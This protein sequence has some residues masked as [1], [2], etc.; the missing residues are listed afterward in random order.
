METIILLTEMTYSRAILLQGMLANESIPSFLSNINQIQSDVSAGVKVMI[1]KSDLPVALRI[2]QKM[3][4]SSE[5]H[6][7][8]DLR[9]LKAIRRILVPVDFSV[10]SEKAAH[11][12]LG[13]AR[14]LKGTIYLLHA[15]YSPAISATA[16]N[17]TF[18][19]PEGMNTYLKELAANARK[20]INL[21]AEVLRKRIHDE[22]MEGVEV[23]ASLRHGL[24]EDTIAREEES[25]RPGVIVMGTRG[26]GGVLYRTLGSVAGRVV[27]ASH[28]PV[29]AIPANST[30]DDPAQISGVVYA[31]DFDE[32]D[33]RSIENLMT[34]LSPFNLRLYCLHVETGEDPSV[35]E[36][37][38]QQMRKHFRD[39]FKAQQVHC[40]VIHGKDISTAL[41]RYVLNHEVGLIA[42]TARKRNFLQSL[43]YPST[44]KQIL[45]NLNTP[46]L[47]FHS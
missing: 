35:D 33:H 39:H 9:K 16:L 42:T 31:T 41:E 46:V 37:R 7:E 30:I 6:K 13:L 22:R 2:L 1:R 4:E 40:E 34:I 47:V 10:H 23:H 14:E 44:T 43:F 12:A 3:L 36:A 11:F 29:I 25:L 32:Q 8:G 21:L 26:E 5:M 24:A 15:Y 19:Y 38:M 18:T 28:V 17:E 20:Q 27:E 45:F